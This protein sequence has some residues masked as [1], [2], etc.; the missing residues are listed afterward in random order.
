LRSIPAVA[1]V[2]VAFSVSTASVTAAPEHKNLQVLDKNITKDELKKTMNEFA[3]QLGVKCTFCHIPDQFEKDD[4]KHKLDARKMIKL[5]QHMRANRADY[6][7]PTVKPEEITC[8]GCHRGKPEPE[9]F[10]P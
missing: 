9:P 1:S 2:L 8:A 10:V 3:E 5:V 6:F 7:K 4:R